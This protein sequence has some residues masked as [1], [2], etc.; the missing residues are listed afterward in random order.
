MFEAI[1]KFNNRKSG[2]HYYQTQ[3]ADNKDDYS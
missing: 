3:K 2:R 1:E